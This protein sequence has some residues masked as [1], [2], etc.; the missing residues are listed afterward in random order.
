MAARYSD[1]EINAVIQETKPLPEGW[2]AKLR[3]KEKPG[4][5][6]RDFDLSG[7]EGNEFRIT[8][9]QN[10]INVLDFSV[11]LGV[12]V[13]ES[14]QVFRLLRYNGK[15]H[16]HTN[17]LEAET[18]YDFHIHRATERYQEQGPREDAYAEPTDRYESLEEAFR[19]LMEDANLQ[20]PPDPQ[21]TLFGERLEL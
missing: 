20:A 18:F 21:G 3:L 12:R 4:H 15:S 14:N 11:I 10:R 16:E 8:L 13:P 5:R 1:P 2:R 9:R 6:E 19:C 17:R 7:S